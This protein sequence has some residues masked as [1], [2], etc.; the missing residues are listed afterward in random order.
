[1]DFDVKQL[2][3]TTLATVSS[4]K[5]FHVCRGDWIKNIHDLANCVE[6]LTPEQFRSHVNAN[7]PTNHFSLWIRETLKNPLLAQDL[8][9]DVNLKDQKQFV[10]TI[11]DHIAW[12]EQN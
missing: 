10:K 5:E 7:G 6:S 4:D 8:M 2:K 3:Q 1:M 12:L 11:R 9:F